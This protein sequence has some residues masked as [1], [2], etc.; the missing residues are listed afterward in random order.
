MRS[1]IDA[2]E[3]ELK[4]VCVACGSEEAFMYYDGGYRGACPTCKKTWPEV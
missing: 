2:M 1:A 3:A 4:F